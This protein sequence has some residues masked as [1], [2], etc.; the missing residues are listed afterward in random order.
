LNSNKIPRLI[1]NYVNGKWIASSSD[2]FLD[3]TNPATGKVISRLPLSTRVELDNV[4]AAA[5][6]AFHEWRRTPP[7]VRAGHFFKLKSL[8]EDNF[9]DLARILTIENGKTI[10]E[11]RGSV[12]RGIQNV[13]TAC[14][15]PTAMQGSNLEDIAE[16]IDCAAVR[17]PLGV[18]GCITPFN[19]PAMVP[20]WFFPTAVA[21][22]NTFIV[23][24]SEQTPL[25]QVRIFELLEEAG[26]PP[27]VINLIN[28]DAECA[29]AM[30]DHPDIA[31]ISF[32]GSSV[33]AE[34]V[35]KRGGEN[36]KRVQALGGAKNFAVI[37][38]DADISKTIPALINSVF[39]CAGE[40]CLAISVLLA[41]GNGYEALKDPLIQAAKKLKIGSGLDKSVDMGPVISEKHK[42]RVVQYIEQGNREGARLLLDGRGIVVED[43]PNGYYVGP[44]IFDEVTPDMTIANE[45][46]F[47]PV[48]GIIRVQDLDEALTIIQKNRYGNASSIFTQSG[49]AA[50][51]FKYN[52]GISMLGINIG[53][54]APMAFFMFGGAK[55]SFF[56]DL[57][58]YGNDGIEFYTDKRIVISRWF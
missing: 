18:F 57:K 13:E 29:E 40:R 38:P 25:C 30:L 28:G 56:G 17:Q 23:K 50:R 55:K 3:V 33:V 20:L 37:M 49:A 44:T 11:S 39:G 41:V 54:A 15:I 34:H 14:G 5:K 22:G 10:P 51:K 48:L 12:R 43:H 4:M 8:L 24:P 52:V 16:G 45:E 46:I 42:Q 47:G 19:F 7:V 26:F 36:G 9:E 58:A 1:Q 31:G 6:G 21:C 32:V 35:Y 53:I 2:R 27:G